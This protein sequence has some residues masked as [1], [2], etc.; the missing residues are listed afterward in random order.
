MAKHHELNAGADTVHWG[1]FDAALKPVLKIDSGDTVTLTTISGSPDLLPKPGG[2]LKILPEYAEV[3]ARHTNRVGPHIMTGPI[4]VEGAEPG[5]T[6]EVRI[7]NIQLRQNWGYNVIRPLAGTIPED[8]GQTWRAIQIPIDINAQIAY[9]PWGGRLQLAPFFG[10]MGNAP[11]PVYGRLTSIIPREF[12][13]NIDNK[14]LTAGTTLFLPVFNRGALFSAGDGHAVQG[15]GE[16]CVTAI[17]TAL[18][19]TFELIVRK[20]MKLTLPRAETPTHFITMA[21]DSDFDQAAKQAVREMLRL[22]NEK[23]GLSREDAYSFMSLACDV[24]VTQLVNEHKGAHVMAP[25]A[26]LDMSPRA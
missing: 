6:L 2:E 16:V 9:P 7:K 20:D 21:F 14:E 5:D 25:K 15:D 4:Y 17:E 22:L 12:G 3:Y 18:R 1:Y 10:N 24:R 26:L 23:V 8:F 11:P 13:G 19:G